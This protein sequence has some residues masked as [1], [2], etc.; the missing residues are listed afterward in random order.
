MAWWVWTCWVGAGVAGVLALAVLYVALLRDRSRGRRRCPKCWYDMSGVPGL[1]CPECGREARREKGLFR[2]RRRLGLAAAGV[3]L[4]LVSHVG[5]GM[6][7]AVENGGWTRL[8]PDTVLGWVLPLWD[9]E[10]DKLLAKGIAF[11]PL[12]TSRWE[13]LMLARAEG[14]S[15][16]EGI[17][18]IAS[19]EMRATLNPPFYW[20]SVI[21]PLHSLEGLGLDAWPAHSILRPLFDPRAPT[22][23]RGAMAVLAAFRSDQDFVI[24]ELVRALETPDRALHLDMVRGRSLYAV[25]GATN[26]QPGI[27]MASRRSRDRLHRALIAAMSSVPGHARIEFLDWYVAQEVIHDPRDAGRDLMQSMGLHVS[28]VERMEPVRKPDS[29]ALVSKLKHFDTVVRHG[30][31]GSIDERADGEVVDAVR[32][33]L[34]TPMY[35]LEHADAVRALLRIGSGASNAAPELFSVLMADP[36]SPSR[37]AAAITATMF[38]PDAGVPLLLIA[39]KDEDPGIQRIALLGLERMGVHAAAAIGA[40]E[41]LIADASPDLRETAVESLRR[42]RASL[43]SEA[44]RH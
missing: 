11:S 34:A 17:Q 40:T 24:T 32:A 43:K 41:S 31:L 6:P 21:L 12:P 15:I 28:T 16:A 37:A 10:G 18:Q 2:T 30:A 13:R 39:L 42:I 23:Y 22:V 9:A 8:V 44:S 1:R 25:E 3:V 4:G 20:T 33:C 27:P 7:W 19:A 35:Y 14:R 29:R 38:P 26:T 5:A 36:A